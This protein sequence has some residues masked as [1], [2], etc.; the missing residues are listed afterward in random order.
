M[1]AELQGAWVWVSR[2]G[3]RTVQPLHWA[4]QNLHSN[5]GSIVPEASSRESHRATCAVGPTLCVTCV[6]VMSMRVREGRQESPSLGISGTLELFVAIA[7]QVWMCYRITFV[8]C[9]ER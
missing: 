9:K 3:K 8:V 5:V 4:M 2:E 1:V 7:Q 6:S